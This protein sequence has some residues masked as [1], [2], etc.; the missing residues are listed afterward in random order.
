MHTHTYTHFKHIHKT[1]AEAFCL[2][3]IKL[4]DRQIWKWDNSHAQL[5]AHMFTLLSCCR[6]AVSEMEKL[7]AQLQMFTEENGVFI[8]P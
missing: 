7:S 5:H 4:K 1:E 6:L 8:C 3:H 2:N